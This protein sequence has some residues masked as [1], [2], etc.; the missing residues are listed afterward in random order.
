MPDHSS[1]H[2]SQLDLGVEPTPR[3]CGKWALS[4]AIVLGVIVILGIFGLML[5]ESG[6]KQMAKDSKCGKHQSQ[7]LGAMMAYAISED[8]AWPDPRGRTSEWKLPA[9]PIITALDGAKYTAGA[10]ELLSASQSIPNSLFEC[11]SA[12]WGGPARNVKASPNHADVHWGWHPNNGVA[13]SYAFDW[14]S[15]P[16]PS[17]DR[18][19]LADRELKTHRDFV[20]V[21]FGDAHVKKLKLVEVKRAVGA[22]ITESGLSSSSDIGTGVQPDDDIFSAEGDAGDP[23]TPGKGDPLRAW[24][25]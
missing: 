16:D 7:I 1:T 18:V 25:K 15:P 5:M 21:A 13:V 12:N 14:A 19:I 3:G 22:L 10:F 20:M 2:G 9:G 17:S 11:P 23:L 8:T 4:G 24:V 6:F